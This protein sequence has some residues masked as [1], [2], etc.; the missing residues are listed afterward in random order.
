MQFTRPF[1]GFGRHKGEVVNIMHVSEL[2]DP[3]SAKLEEGTRI[4]IDKLT[5]GNREIKVAEFGR[6]VEYTN[7][8]QQLSKFDPQSVLQKALIRHMDRA[9]DTASAA[10]FQDSS[11]VLTVFVPTSL[12][13]GTF[14]TNG[15]P[16]TVA[17]S[18]MT[19]DLMGV[20]ADYL[21]GNIHA[22]PYEGEDYIML[23]CRKI[24]R[25]LKTDPLW[26]AVHL[27]L[28]KGDLFYKGEVGKVENIRCVACQ[29]EEAISNTAGN[30]TVLG[31]A[32][33]FGDE[34]VTRIEVEPPQLYAD[35]NYQ[36]D[37]GRVKAVAWRGLLAFASIW[38]SASDGQAKIIR[39]TS[40]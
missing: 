9:M 1:P 27:Y 26:Q 29:R 39:V 31:N 22:Y 6:G 36:S 23:A 19:Y 4:P 3:T 34:A 7:L 8:M 33:V 5:F 18:N 28:Q 10:A 35:P 2:P 14:Y 40:A 20:L 11:S 12:T 15:T 32:V 30:S 37:F 25:G 24:L 16:G 13:G 38:D 17:T 21:A